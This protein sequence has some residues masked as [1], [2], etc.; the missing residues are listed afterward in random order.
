V[1][2]N[3]DREEAL[4]EE[5][6]QE[7]ILQEEMV[8]T[9]EQEEQE[10]EVTEGEIVDD[11]SE[12]IAKLEQQAAENF[13][14]YQRSLA[15]FDNFRKRTMKE[16]A[17]MYD[18]GVRDTVEKLLSVVDNLERAVAA[19][20]GKAEGNDSFLKGVQMILKQ[21]QE[22]L[23]G[24]GVEEI[25]ALGEKFDPNLHAAVAHEDDEN[26]GENE[27]ILEMLKGYQYKDKVIRHSMVKVAN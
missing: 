26:Y 25:K 1:A 13:D 20:E 7:E 10:S 3:K 18:D 24:L 8:E 22:I 27:I 6:L 23:H 2:E 15:E 5:V 4:K 11:T 17:T 16:K 14:K 9:T 12:K 21:F 19:Q